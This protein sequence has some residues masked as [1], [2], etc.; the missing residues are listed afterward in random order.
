MKK[1]VTAAM[2]VIGDEI[3]SGRT[4]DLNIGHL[5]DIMTAIGI[6][7]KEVRIVCVHDR[8]HRPH[9]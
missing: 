6:D 8:R 4:K 1:Q 5:A 3:L 7:L 9:P 2:I